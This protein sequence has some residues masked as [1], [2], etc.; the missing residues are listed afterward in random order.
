MFGSEQENEFHVIS[1]YIRDMSFPKN[2]D[3]HFYLPT[4]HLSISTF[5][6]FPTF[7]SPADL[8]LSRRASSGPGGLAAVPAD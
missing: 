5:P 2:M 6:T 8:Q 4:K 1:V 3:F 7:P